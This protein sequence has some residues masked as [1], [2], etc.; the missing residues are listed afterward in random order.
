MSIASRVALPVRSRLRERYPFAGLM[1]CACRACAIA[2]GS[3]MHSRQ[4][5]LP[6]KTLPTRRL[7]A[8]FDAEL[9]L[10]WTSAMA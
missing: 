10:R 2:Q 7:L 4:P 8:A 1:A 6:K 9:R 3:P 5:A